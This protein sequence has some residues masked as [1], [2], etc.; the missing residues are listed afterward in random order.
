LTITDATRVLFRNGPTG[1]SLSD[2][3]TEDTIIAGL[4]E[5]ALDA[6]ALQFLGLKAEDVPFLRLAEERGLG[7]A[8]WR[9][10]DREDVSI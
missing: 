6:Y 10:L 9:L 1:G 5:V 2:V 8:D 3:S 7:V 4:D